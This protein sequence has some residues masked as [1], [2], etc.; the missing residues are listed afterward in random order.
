MECAHGQCCTF[1]PGISSRFVFRYTENSFCLTAIHDWLLNGMGGSWGMKI[2]L[3]GTY[4]KEDDVQVVAGRQT[5]I[6]VNVL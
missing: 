6:F 3:Q 4:A 1:I 2:A 5:G